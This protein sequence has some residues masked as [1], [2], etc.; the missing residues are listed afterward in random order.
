M[1]R[2]VIII[3]GVCLHP[4]VSANFLSTN[5]YIRLYEEQ[6]EE[7]L[8]NFRRLIVI[9]G[10]RG[11]GFNGHW[12]LGGAADLE[13]EILQ[14]QFVRLDPPHAEGPQQT[15]GPAAVAGGHARVERGARRR[16]GL[17]VGLRRS[18]R[19]VGEMRVLGRVVGGIRPLVL[20]GGDDVLVGWQLGGALPEVAL[21]DRKLIAA[22]DLIVAWHAE[23]RSVHGPAEGVGKTFHHLIRRQT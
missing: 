17:R 6:M 23:R 20:H 2:N 14:V 22:D 11:D 15:A 19:A 8:L 13:A 9:L 3:S 4:T 5:L 10:R 21:P 16:G 12:V 7:K 1:D 18:R